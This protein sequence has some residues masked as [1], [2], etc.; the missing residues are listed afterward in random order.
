MRSG[1]QIAKAD[2]KGHA[3]LVAD[4]RRLQRHA[5]L[6]ADH[7]SPR[8]KCPP[9]EAFIWIIPDEKERLALRTPW[10]VLRLGART[11][12]SEL[13]DLPSASIAR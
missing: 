5:L 13:G 12:S 1:G 8:P 4:H 11:F 6:V 2:C 7:L 9:Q 3:L 10:A